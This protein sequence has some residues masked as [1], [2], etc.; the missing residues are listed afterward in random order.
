MPLTLSQSPSRAGRSVLWSLIFLM[1]LWLLLH[2]DSAQASSAAGGGL[3]YEDWLARLRASVTGPI[4]FTLSILGIIGAGSMLIFGGDLNG[5]FRALV[6]LVLVIGLL[7]GAQ[8]L[9]SGLFGQG[10]MLAGTLSPPPQA[11]Q[12][13]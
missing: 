3:P 4:A 6:L 8:N 7:V 13:V 1:V 9:M 12:P 11:D 2:T 10:A 5:F